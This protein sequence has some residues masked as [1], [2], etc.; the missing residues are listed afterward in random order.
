MLCPNAQ[1]ASAHHSKA[2]YLYFLTNIDAEDLDSSWND[3]VSSIDIPTPEV[4]TC[5]FYKLSPA[6]F[7][8]KLFLLLNLLCLGYYSAEANKSRDYGCKGEFIQ[9]Y[10]DDDDYFGNLDEYGFNDQ[11]SSFICDR[12]A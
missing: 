11:I 8:A 5:E 1:S 4:G 12:L 3:A 6:Q 7:S 9:S 10:Y 2:L